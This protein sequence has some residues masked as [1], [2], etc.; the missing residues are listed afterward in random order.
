[1]LWPGCALIVIFRS[2]C[3]RLCFIF[4]CF[5][6]GELENCLYSIC[7]HCSTLCCPIVQP[8]LN[9][10]YFFLSFYHDSDRSFCYLFVGSSLQT[11]LLFESPAH[12]VACV[13]SSIIHFIYHAL[14]SG[15]D[16][17]RF[18]FILVKYI[19]IMLA[20]YSVLLCT[21]LNWFNFYYCNFVY[22]IGWVHKYD[23]K[24]SVD[25]PKFGGGGG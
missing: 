20:V 13:L 21:A 15:N 16:M 19:R 5:F 2:D 12:A 24:F 7:R 17:M 6:C 9:S 14:S 10:S 23:K 22:M 18:D 3:Y 1:M 11:A 4:G 8:C 25:Q